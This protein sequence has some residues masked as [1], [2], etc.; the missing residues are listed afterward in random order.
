[1]TGPADA[2]VSCRI[3]GGVVDEFLDLGRQ[4]LSD[5]FLTADDLA[6]EF[7]YRSPWGSVNGCT[8]VQLMEE[9]PR[10]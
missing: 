1:M 6:G 9:V 2:T 10:D 3:C 5:R 7:F 8:M 4:P